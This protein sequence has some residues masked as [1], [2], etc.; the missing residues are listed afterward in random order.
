MLKLFDKKK[1]WAVVTGIHGGTGE[2]RISRNTADGKTVALSFPGM[3][4]FRTFDTDELLLA[5]SHVT[6]PVKEYN[7]IKEKLHAS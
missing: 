1:R 5:L 7:K 2:L 4:G 6:M 3:N